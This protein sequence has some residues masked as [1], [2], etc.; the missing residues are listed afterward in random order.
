MAFDF[1]K[2]ENCL[3][4]PKPTKSKLP[5]VEYRLHYLSYALTKHKQQQNMNSSFIT[6]S[7][8][9]QQ[10]WSLAGWVSLEVSLCLVTA[11]KL[12]A[13]LDKN[14]QIHI[15]QS[16]VPNQQLL[17]STGLRVAGPGSIPTHQPAVLLFP[18]ISTASASHWTL[19]PESQNRERE[20][21]AMWKEKKV[22]KSKLPL[23]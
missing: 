9:L 14:K 2:P 16:P 3:S 21:F 8:F 23:S 13:G 17:T 7:C 18:G 20:T 1:Y 19:L 11:S 15:S 6:H 12:R 4:G 5:T 10:T 22:R